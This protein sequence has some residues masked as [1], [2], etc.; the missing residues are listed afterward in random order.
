M[1]KPALIIL[2]LILIGS[3]L[4]LAPGCSQETT[5]I[6]ESAPKTEAPDPDVREYADYHNS[7]VERLLRRNRDEGCLGD[8]L[9]LEFEALVREM[10][11]RNPRMAVSP[12]SIRQ[13]KAL[14][15]SIYRIHRRGHR[16]SE[17]KH[18]WENCLKD[19]CR[20]Q[21][22]HPE[23]IKN[24]RQSVDDL[25]SKSPDQMA[26]QLK[27]LEKMANEIGSQAEKCVVGVFL[28]SYERSWVHLG[29]NTKFVNLQKIVVIW[30]M[31]GSFVG[32]A[33]IG[34]IF[35]SNAEIM[36]AGLFIP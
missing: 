22:V 21:D 15:P 32:G 7:Q 26:K 19:F 3:L 24:L 5:G 18:L 31:I 34:A 36:V 14:L 27:Q 25:F 20:N 35:S 1:Q 33:G 29:E 12:E 11:S 30:D 6:T 13:G 10:G 23:I 2:L 4:S 28:G 16:I 8:G 9:V 17:V